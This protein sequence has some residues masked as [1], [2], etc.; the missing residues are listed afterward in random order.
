MPTP[1]STSGEYTK[2]HCERLTFSIDLFRNTSKY[3]A[4]EKRHLA[5]FLI[6]VVCDAGSRILIVGSMMFTANCWVF[7]TKL[8]VA[9]FYGMLALM[10]VANAIFCYIE[11][12]RIWS[13]R[14]LIGENIFW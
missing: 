13:L 14:N 9:Y 1:A 11:K 2:N 8:T 10:L 7:S 3:E 6:K 4:L 12:E 5:V